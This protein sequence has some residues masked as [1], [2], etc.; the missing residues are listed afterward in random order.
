MM[1]SRYITI[2]IIT[3][4]LPAIA[5]A[6]TET[7]TVKIAPFSSDKYDEFSP[8]FYKNGVVFCTNRNTSLTSYSTSQDKGLFKINYIDTAGKV[9]WQNAR[10]L[11]K[12]LTTKLNDG[13]VAFNGTG[14]TIYYVR[15]L[16]VNS[17]IKNISNK[18]NK[19]GLFSA[20]LVDGKWT[21]IRELRINNDMYNLIT[22]YLSQDG[23]KLYLASDKPGGYGGFDLYYCIWMGDYWGDLVNLGPVINTT[24]NEAYPFI[25]PAGGL[26]FSSDGHPGLGGKDIFFSKYSD[27]AWFAPVPLD[28]PVNSVKD[29]F[30]FIC[31]SVMNSGY[32]SSNRDNTVD[33]FHFKT[34][35]HQPFYCNDQRVNQ[36]CFQFTDKETIRINKN[37]LQYEWSFGDGTKTKGLDVNHCFPGAGKY[38]VKLNVIEKSSGRIFFTKLSFDLEL[39]DVEQPFINSVAAGIATDTIAFDGMKSNLPMYKITGYS[40]DFGDGTKS[41]GERVNHLFRAKGEYEVRLVV[42]S[43]NE[44]T[45]VINESCVTRKVAVF[46]TQQESAAQIIQ[47]NDQDT[48]INILEYDHAFINNYYSVEKFINQ[49]AVFQVEILTSKTRLGTGSPIFRSVPKKFAISEIFLSADSMYRYYISEEMSLMAAYPAYSEMVT[50]GYKNTI[51]KPFILTDPAKKELNILKN[52]YSLS[53]D[54]FFVSYSNSISS[55]GFALL[56][57]I[58]VL[59]NK[60]PSVKLEVAAHTDNSG[61]P[62]NNLELSQKR[63]ETMVNY[64]VQRGIK[65]SRLSGRGFG[66]TKPVAPNSIEA[67]RK[68]NRRVD[69]SIIGD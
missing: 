29:D 59:M 43:L 52:V 30:G 48:I 11:S 21:K 6:Q 63:A 17:S 12:E 57:Q 24:G 53:A 60:Y 26:F 25:N 27:T 31:D 65:I 56:D 2:I 55:N 19:L 54:Q 64:L 69:F 32:F 62:G 50:A 14:D 20:I 61:L 67:D 51:I 49:D 44:S 36:Y 7:Y 68:L 34:N 35:F 8:V 39:K 45:G 28:S 3:L 23:K 47:T 5:F 13:P 33:I 4:F 41:T 46:N 9:T 66:G 16:E 40:W 58:V 38:E 22:P 18:R 42:T 1:I 37:T 10:L 15:N